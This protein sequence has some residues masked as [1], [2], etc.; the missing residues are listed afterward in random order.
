M[1]EWVYIKTAT[2]LSFTVSVYFYRYIWPARVLLVW[3]IVGECHARNPQTI[4]FG[5]NH[6]RPLH[7]LSL[8]LPTSHEG[9]EKSISLPP[10]FPSY[11]SFRDNSLSLYL[12]RR[13]AWSE[14]FCQASSSR[15]SQN[16]GGRCYI[17]DDT[18]RFYIS[19]MTG[20]RDA[21]L[22]LRQWRVHKKSE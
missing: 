12:F 14:Y 5:Q 15:P 10:I 8:S 4:T 3:W 17:E 20:F 6:K 7:P 21:S 19:Y 2:Y 22:Q 13:K 1:I 11:P 9:W 16:N 18:V